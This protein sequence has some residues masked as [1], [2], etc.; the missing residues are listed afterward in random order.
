MKI[1]LYYIKIKRF[2]NKFGILSIYNQTNPSSLLTLTIKKSFT[3]L[4][5]L[6]FL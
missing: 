5:T 1:H 6:I 2:N 3:Y 4:I